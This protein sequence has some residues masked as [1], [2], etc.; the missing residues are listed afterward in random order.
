MKKWRERPTCSNQGLP[1]T[2]GRCEQLLCHVMAADA[3][4]SAPF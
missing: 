4:V 1:L 3:F 2:P